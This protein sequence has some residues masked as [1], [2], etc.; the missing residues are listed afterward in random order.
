MRDVTLL[1]KI[2]QKSIK[3]MF[4]LKDKSTSV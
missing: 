2:H 3:R 1:D 4:Q